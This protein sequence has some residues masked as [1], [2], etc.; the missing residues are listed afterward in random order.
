MSRPLRIEL[1][2]GLYHVTLRGDRRE[3]IYCDDQDRT[4]WL[5]VVGEV[6]SRFNWRCHAWCKMTNHC[7]LVVETPY[8][9][10][11]QGP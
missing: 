4:E 11:S 8:A 6:C 3:T 7:H 2:G 9:N 10:L 1:A 5:T